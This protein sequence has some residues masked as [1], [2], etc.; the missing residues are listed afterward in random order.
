MFYKM[1]LLTFFTNV[2]CTNYG[3][4]GIL[5][6]PILS[7]INITMFPLFFVSH[8]VLWTIYALVYTSPHTILNSVKKDAATQSSNVPTYDYN[9]YN[10]YNNYTNYNGMTS[11]YSVQTTHEKSKQKVFI[12]SFILYFISMEIILYMVRYMVCKSA[13]QIF[14]Y[15]QQQ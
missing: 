15:Y 5:L 6:S 1:D 11:S 14:D 2:V 12:I 4:A 10:N 7:L 8:A 9:H 3:I 13:P